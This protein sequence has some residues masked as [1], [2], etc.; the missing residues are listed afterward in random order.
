MAIRGEGGKLQAVRSGTAKAASAGRSATSAASGAATVVTPGGGSR[1]VGIILT[2]GVLVVGNEFIQGGSVAKLFRPAAAFL[3]AAWAFSAL[4]KL[5]EQ[6]AVGLASIVM[7]T[8]LIGGVN[9]SYKSPAA[10]IISIFSGSGTTPGTGA[11]PTPASTAA[12]AAA[13]NN[14]GAAPTQTGA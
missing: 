1:S 4:E 6:A 9:S 14:A 10:E 12:Q 8:V 2:A 13:P 11:A 5:D 3:F 7:I